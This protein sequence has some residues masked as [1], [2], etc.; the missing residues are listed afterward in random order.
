MGTKSDRAGKGT[1]VLYT[2]WSVKK[3][4]ENEI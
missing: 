1:G 3:P 4:K 2:G